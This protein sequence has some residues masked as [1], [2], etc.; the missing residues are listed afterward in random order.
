MD[1]DKVLVLKIT[2]S[3]RQ[4]RGGFQYP[5]FGYVECPDWHPSEECGGGL[6]GW[7]NG[8][9]DYRHHFNTGVFLV[10]EAD[11]RDV[12]EKV[13]GGGKCKIRRGYVLYSGTREGAVAV[14]KER[15]ALTTKSDPAWACLTPKQCVTVSL[16]SADRAVRRHAA[17]ALRKAGLTEQADKLSGLPVIDSADAARAAADAADYAARGH[18]AADAADY[19]ARAARA[20]AAADYAA[21]G[22]AA[23]AHYAARAADAAD[24]ADE[25]EANRLDKLEMLGIK[26]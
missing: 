1:S 9:G 6:H 3:N 26:E 10:I 18:A 24:A 25:R 17:D 19:A 20:A 15:G 23:A 21:R 8:E 14:L 2:D 7:L 11:R 4:G 13:D 16:R 12:V 22:H 5:A